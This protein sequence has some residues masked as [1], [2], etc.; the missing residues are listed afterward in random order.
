MK[1]CILL[2][3]SMAMAWTSIR[4]PSARAGEIGFIEQFALAADREAALKQLI[5]GTEDFYYFHCLHYLNLQ[6]WEKVDAMHKAWVDRYQYTP[7]AIEIQNRQALLMYPND[8]QRALTLIRQRLNLQFNHQRELLNQKP[9]L[10]TTLDP[11]LLDMA[12][13]TENA[14][15]RYPNTVQGFENAALDRLAQMQLNPDQRRH[16]LSRL[17]RPDHKNMA[18]LVVDDL[19]HANS[20]GFG[21]WEIHRQLLLA[22][23]DECLKL[24]PDL[25][26]Q[27]N[28]VNAYIAKLHPTPDQNWRQ[29]PQAL[30]AYLDRLWSFVS[31]LAPV[32]NSLKAHVLYH[33]LAYDRSRGEFNAERFL[34]YLQLPRIAP[35][36]LEKYLQHPDRVNVRAQLAVDYSP[37]TLLPPVNDDEPLVRSFLLHFFVKA[38]N[39][40]AYQAYVNDSYLKHLF[41]EAKIVGGLGDPEKWYSLL[42]P[43][44]YQALK[45]RID[46]DFAP[47]NKIEY[48]V[49]DAVGLD[50]DV[51]NV[52]TLIVKVFEINTQ[53]F[54][55]Q[56]LREISTDINLDGLVANHEQTFKYDEPPLRRVRRHFNFPRIK[57]RG[58]YVVDFIGN[59]MSSRALVRKG[60]FKYLVRTSSAGQIFNILDEGNQPLPQATLW[61]AGTLYTPDKSGEITVP[62][63]NQPGRQ[64]IVLSHGGY[65]TLTSFNQEAE[66]YQLRAAMYVDR[67]ELIQRRTAHLLIRSELALNGLPISIK[68]LQDIRLTI[69]ST[70]LDGVQTTKEVADFPLF[71]DRD[72]VHPFQVPQRLATISFTLRAKVQN[73]SQNQKVDVAAQQSFGLNEIDRTDKFEDLH[74]SRVGNDYVIDV[75]GKT[76]EAQPDRPVQL[77]FKLRD[78]TE[79]VHATLQTD[80]VGR[81]TLGPLPGVLLVTATGPQGTA[82]TWPLRHD[83]H[84]A[85]RSLHAE[86]GQPVFVPFMS[87]A[88]EPVTAEVSLLEVR[89][90]TFVADYVGN[91]TVENGML[92]IEKLPPG[93]YSLLLKD[94][95]VQIHLRLSQGVRQK[96]VLLGDFRQL[97]LNQQRP[98]QLERVNIEEKTIRAHVRNAGKFTRVHV[99]GTRF[100]PAYSAY[101]SLASI[102]APEP[103]SRSQTRSESVYI[104]GRNIGDEYRYIIDRKFARKFPGNMLDRPSLLLNPWAVRG[105]ET[106]Q[107]DAQAGD[108]FA[109]K[110]EAAA[111]ADSD[112]KSGGEGVAALADFAN[113]DFLAESSLVLANLI[114]DE[115]GFVEL[116]RDAL[117]AHQEVLF[118]AVDPQSTAS[119]VVALPRAETAHLD[120]RLHKGLDPDQHYTQQKQIKY[121]ATGG[122][123]LLRDIASSRFEAYDHLGRV[124][125]LLATLNADPT[126]VEFGFLLNWPN[127]KPEEK[128]EQ[129]SKYACHEL[130]FFLYKKDPAFF[131]EVVKPYLA[132]KRAKTFLDHWLLE[133][134]LQEYSRPWNFQQLN[135]F[136]RALLGQ[137]LA[138]DGSSTSRF[139]R[140]QYELLPPQIDRFNHLFGTALQ[141]SSLDLGDALGIQEQLKQLRADANGQDM[142][143][144]RNDAKG[145]ADGRLAGRAA[146]PG[147]PP[148]APSAAARPGKP[149]E[150]LGENRR[151]L[152]KKATREQSAS[153]RDRAEKAK[154]AASDEAEEMDRLEENADFYFEDASGK[155]P[156]VQQYYRKLDKTME[157]AENNY[158]HLLNEQMNESLIPVSAFWNDFAARDPSQPFYSRN[159]A[160]AGRNV[161]EMLLALAV[162]D[163]PFTAEEHKTAFDGPQMAFTA[164]S[165]TIVYYEEI[166]PAQPGEQAPLLIGQNFFRHGD[167]HQQ[168]NNETVDKF[169]T[170]EFLTDV[171]YGAHI[172]VTNPTSTPR[173]IDVLLQIP[174]G[175]LPLLNGQATKSVHLDLQ[176]YQTHTLEYFFYFPAAGSFAHYPVQAASQGEVLAF[177]SPFTFNVVVEPTIID[178]DSWDYISQHG[179]PEDVTAF[180]EKHNLQRLNLDRIA[181]RM[182]DK[183][184][185]EKTIGLLAARHVYNHT[186]YSYGV[187]HNEP[188]AIRQFLQYAD[189]FVQQCGEDLRSPLLVI[190][191]VV[192]KTYEHL[193]YKPLVNARVGQLGRSRQILNDRFFD[194]Y[195]RLLKI[196]GYHYEFDDQDLMAVTYYMLLQDRVE[197]GLEFFARVNPDKLETRMQYDYCAAYLNF[198]RS[199][200]DAAREIAAR[201]ANHPVDRWKNTFQA[202]LNQVDE[203]T[204]PDVL[205][206]DA[207]DRNQVQT[208]Q[209]AKAATF[210]FTVESRKIKVNYQNLTKVKVNYYLMDI[211]LLF[212]RN[213]FVQQTAQQFSY[214]QPNASDVVELPAKQAELE[215]ALPEQF[216][217]SNVLVEITGAGE[218]KTQAYYANGLNT[219]VIE[220][221]GQVRVTQGKESAPLSKVYVKVYARMN[222]GSVRFYKDGY[223]DLRGRFDYTSLNT[224][225]LEIVN[226]FSL[227]VLSEE[228][229]A[230]VREA[231]PPKR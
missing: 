195:H 154:D 187:S 181:F 49:D 73:H 37:V 99:F 92:R 129:Y 80:A 169:V 81:V 215:F 123:L 15:G 53:N 8:P 210:D 76:G 201:Y 141:S 170:R 39:Y 75:Y 71:E 38:E 140:E 33:R 202:V 151:G 59:G 91:V 70:D 231:N 83:E 186:L 177:A 220:N 82:H 132:N 164:G 14:F 204:R 105:T 203:I 95:N 221:Y 208:G 47:T 10:P 35:Y 205:V 112:R 190:D 155:L 52:P 68:A 110:G 79:L 185:F 45:E 192:R 51:K 199:Q 146:A 89:G 74:F 111:L 191:P 145:A 173:K 180:L 94:R 87:L 103:W 24:K 193:D 136:E 118:V 107:Q 34:E 139:I 172:V 43:A 211:E 230:I 93:D 228:H 25:R 57:D 41:A 209:A 150:A 48:G 26:N 166:Q 175:S 64:P 50:L 18:Q 147:A 227:L 5:P 224:N 178:K 1:R 28:F 98:L 197:E 117:G 56:N 200:P 214:I 167:R 225:E 16:L 161:H 60:Q 88:D 159:M 69:T 163:L 17:T 58:V 97:E 126:F 63:S 179:S 3:A 12:R 121:L 171:V 183:A 44:T 72:A 176:P 122:E 115:D 13:L 196:L 101:F 2:V 67:E 174:V 86:A 153:K 119:R 217:R 134:D 120:L 128:R 32:H 104:A 66:S 158:Y 78:Y 194:Q 96:G 219:Q 36:M 46:L 144:Y 189:G 207:E 168:V 142:L 160:E 135:T 149:S 184:F 6:Q 7:R 137:R 152:Q 229:G 113:L 130:S 188:A 62:F 165:P 11:A 20:G 42:P 162:L 223:T 131:A 61:L 157:W 226:R 133:N 40:Q 114:P 222:D 84:S 22:Q 198:Y 108:M 106:A 125:A 29:D 55:R 109:P 138:E 124:Y 212:S 102:A 127:L 31:T 85:P 65:A 9:N 148:P 77:A 213:P 100:Q 218:T 27:G 23:L 143:M 90:N 30:A 19:N 156:E 54:Y 4:V 216:H 182:Q 21:Q 116:Q 206:A